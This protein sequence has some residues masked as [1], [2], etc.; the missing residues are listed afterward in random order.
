MTLGYD[1][2]VTQALARFSKLH[3]RVSIKGANVDE[4]HRV[5]GACEQL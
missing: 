2:G 3:V 4:F 1:R 5:T